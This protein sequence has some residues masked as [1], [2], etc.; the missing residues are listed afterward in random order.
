MRKK[1]NGIKVVLLEEK[2]QLRSES[3]SRCLK[4][5]QGIVGIWNQQTKPV[6]KIYEY[7]FVAV[8]NLRTHFRE[9][10]Q[11]V[12]LL[13]SC[14]PKTQKYKISL[15][16]DFKKT[17]QTKKLNEFSFEGKISKVAFFLLR[18]AVFERFCS[19]RRTS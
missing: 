14:L 7:D 8:V 17:M 12:I 9:T 15:S 3:P 11:Y 2:N 10:D 6:Q 19:N 16:W 4:Q 13:Q 1:K 5:K 18:I